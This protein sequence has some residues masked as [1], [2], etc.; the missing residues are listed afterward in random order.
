MDFHDQGIIISKNFIRDNTYVITVFTK[1]H[2]LYSGVIK[3]YGKKNGDI[4]IE[5]NFIDFSWRARLHEHLGSAKCELI[6]AY[7]SYIISNK[8]KLYAFNSI[9]ALIQKAFCERENHNNFFPKLLEYLNIL[10]NKTNFA[11]TDYLK[12][13]L[14]LLNE[15]GY[16]LTIDQCVLTKSKT[17]LCYVSPRSAS[18]VSKLAAIGYEDKLL[19]LPKFLLNSSEEENQIELKKG[20]DLISYFLQRYV[21]HK[22]NLKQ[23]EQLINIFF[24]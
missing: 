3:Q 19:P 5:S 23:R 13:E 16:G 22:K 11:F 6:K 17:D 1:N 21:L 12:I 2:G 20:L 24:P 18:A 10:K 4:L 7:S 14:D 9:A 8:A 15:T